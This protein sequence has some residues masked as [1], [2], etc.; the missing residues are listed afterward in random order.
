MV[1]AV[2][3]TC[4]AH[5]REVTEEMDES[6]E[7]RQRQRYLKEEPLLQPP[8]PLLPPPLVL[9]PPPRVETASKFSS[10]SRTRGKVRS[11]KAL[12]ALR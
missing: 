6:V 12:Q 4:V 3:A 5:A 7:G 9:Q 11:S 1:R 8:P 10:S 2:L